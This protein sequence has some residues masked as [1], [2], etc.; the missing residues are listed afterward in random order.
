MEQENYWFATRT[1]QQ[2]QQNVELLLV[3]LVSYCVYVWMFDCT[4]AIRH[5]L[6]RIHLIHWGSTCGVH[7]DGH[8]EGAVAIAAAT[9]HRRRQTKRGHGSSS[10]CPPSWSF[11]WN[12]SMI[13]KT[14]TARTVA[15]I[16]DDHADQLNELCVCALLLITGNAAR[17]MQISCRKGAIATQL[18]VLT[19]SLWYILTRH[20]I[21]H[22]TDCQL[23]STFTW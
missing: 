8:N 3:W 16:L 1:L 18:S 2:T 11:D 6:A 10:I 17:S 5:S 12:F 19:R 15:I 7:G 21:V 22:S 20:T 14:T 4:C 9:F 13:P 23:T